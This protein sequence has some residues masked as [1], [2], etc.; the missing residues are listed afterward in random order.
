M[1]GKRQFIKALGKGNERIMIPRESRMLVLGWN[2]EETK[3]GVLDDF[4]ALTCG[5]ESTV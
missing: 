3:H 1:E 4:R 5:I 2:L